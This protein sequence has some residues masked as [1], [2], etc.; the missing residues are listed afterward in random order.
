MISYDA[1][2]RVLSS[3]GFEQGDPHHSKMGEYWFHPTSGEVVVPKPEAGD[4]HRR[5]IELIMDLA[6]VHDCPLT[7][8]LQFKWLSDLA[9][10][11]DAIRPVSVLPEGEHDHPTE[12][13]LLTQD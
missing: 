1:M 7:Y 5:M 10:Q 4:Y 11:V 12:D 13:D 8:E 3:L 9:D 2:T 6:M